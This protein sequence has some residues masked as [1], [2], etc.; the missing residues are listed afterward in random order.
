[1][2]NQKTGSGYSHGLQLPPL[3]QVVGRAGDYPAG[4]ILPRAPRIPSLFRQ[5]WLELAK[6]YAVDARIVD[7]CAVD[8]LDAVRG[9]HGL[10]WRFGSSLPDWSI[11]KK[12]LPALEHGLDMV[13]FPGWKNLWWVQDKIAQHYLLSTFGVPTPR[14]WV[15]WDAKA[16]QDFCRDTRFPLVLKLAVG[17]AG[18]NVSLLRNAREASYWIDR[19]FGSGV[20]ALDQRHASRRLAI[21]QRLRAVG[22]A[23][24]MKGGAMER[25]Y[26]YLQEFL[27]GNEGDTRVTIIGHRAYAFRR[28][29]RPGDF[30]AS[31]SGLIDHAP[32]GISEHAV[33]LAFEVARKLET[34][35]LALDL[36][37]RE[38]QWVVIELNFSFV[39][40]FVDAC[41]G[42]WMKGFGDDPQAIRW[43]DQP[44]PSADALFEDFLNALGRR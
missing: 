23:M 43:V 7:V 22:R 25:G 41:P 6:A 1:M 32:E 12:V 3:L 36:M 39:A 40:K 27:P 8:F 29:N 5:G 42:F 13:V 30:R 44:K 10:M 19:L 17:S 28:R 21:E 9:C 34:D 11:A 33:R 15:F 4:R 26:L 24:L 37:R 18:T 38:E 31:G 20:P 2:N 14:T 35:C 16:A